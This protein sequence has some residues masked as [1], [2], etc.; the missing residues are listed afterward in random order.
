MENFNGS[1]K[2]DKIVQAITEKNLLYDVVAVKR[3][4][5]STKKAAMRQLLKVR[6]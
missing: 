1:Y 4:L 2:L 3:L 6:A 5:Q